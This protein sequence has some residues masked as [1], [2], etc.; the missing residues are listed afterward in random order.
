MDYPGYLSDR[1]FYR[2]N[3]YVNDTI[4]GIDMISKIDATTNIIIEKRFPTS[5]V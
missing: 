5:P 3:L 1:R 4:D 2:S